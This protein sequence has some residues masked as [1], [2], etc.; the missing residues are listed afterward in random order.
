MLGLEMRGHR[1]SA[2]QHQPHKVD[3]FFPHPPRQARRLE[4]VLRRSK[5][6]RLVGKVVQEYEPF[7]EPLH[8]SANLT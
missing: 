7:S 4:E 1:G 6:C 5:C 2:G 3:F 8:I